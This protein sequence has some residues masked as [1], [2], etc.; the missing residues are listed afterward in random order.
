MYKENDV[1]LTNNAGT[2]RYMA[3]ELS[4]KY[5]KTIFILNFII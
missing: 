2:E 3:Q 4:F 5:N 1:E